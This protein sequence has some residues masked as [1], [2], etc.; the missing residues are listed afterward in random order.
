MRKTG[1]MDRN[2][3]R[4]FQELVD[5]LI[6]LVPEDFDKLNCFMELGSIKGEPKMFYHFGCPDLPDK[7]FST[8]TERL[9][10]AATSLVDYFSKGGN[11]FPGFRIY[12]ERQAGG[13]WKNDIQRLDT[14]LGAQLQSPILR[15]LER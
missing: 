6:E 5:A 4:V 9:D 14:Q 2:L 7:S 1:L 12:M 3:F 11:A 8:S 13:N 15:P 10:R